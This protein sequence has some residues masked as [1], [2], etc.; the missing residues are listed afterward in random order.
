MAHLV[1]GA[2]GMAALFL[3]KTYVQNKGISIN[4]WQWLLT[5]LGLLYAV[6]VVELIYGFLA[7]GEP[8][9][10][11]VMGLVTGIVAVIW[12]VLLSRFTF[13]AVEEN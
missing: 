5:I 8:Q 2:V 3:L 13:K 10:A 12:G 11:L 7:E 1:I 6:F 4:W 9:A